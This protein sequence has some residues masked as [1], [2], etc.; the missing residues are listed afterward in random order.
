MIRRRPD[1]L[2]GEHRFG[3]VRFVSQWMVQG[4]G[5]RE[6]EGEIVADRSGRFLHLQRGAAPAE[7]DQQGQ[8]PLSR[9]VESG[10]LDPSRQGDTHPQGFTMIL[11]PRVA[12]SRRG[13][14]RRLFR[15]RQ[16]DF[17][18]ERQGPLPGF[19]YERRQNPLLYLAGP[20]ETQPEVRRL[21]LSTGSAS[22]IG[23]CVEFE[24]TH[25]G[26]E[27]H[28]GRLR[29]ER[30]QDAIDLKSG[31]AEAQPAHDTVTR[32]VAD[33]DLGGKMDGDAGSPPPVRQ[34]PRWFGRGCRYGCDRV[35]GR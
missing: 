8:R 22:I 17:H 13:R 9:D 24:Q 5:G 28:V 16:E 15:Q 29:I 31:A 14:G 34:S 11:P 19:V 3:R 26:F 20:G 7:V 10:G 2:R 1:D 18:G 33:R 32:H 27:D 23:H 25:G 12:V 21:L 30:R 4:T 6:I 35:R